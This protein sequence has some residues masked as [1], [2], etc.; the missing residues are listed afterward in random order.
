MGRAEKVLDAVLRDLQTLPDM[1]AVFA[2]IQDDAFPNIDPVHFVDADSDNTER[3][4]G[5]AMALV[6][7]HC[8][9]RGDDVYVQN[10]GLL[11]AEPF[12]L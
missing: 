9:L 2:H 12:F 11:V 10:N 5:L 8:E 4:V 1:S 3:E 7:H 6:C